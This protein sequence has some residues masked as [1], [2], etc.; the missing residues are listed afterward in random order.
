MKF[1][2]NVY[3]HNLLNLIEFQGQGQI[4]FVCFVVGA[5]LH[6]PTDAQNVYLD[7][8]QKPIGHQ[9]HRVFCA[10]FCLHDTAVLNVE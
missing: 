8:L 10:S 6:L 1:C 2:V 7:N 4:G 9:G 3:L 5:M